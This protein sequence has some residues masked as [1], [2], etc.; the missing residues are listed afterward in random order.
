MKDLRLKEPVLPSVKQVIEANQR[1]ENNIYQ[2]R[3]CHMEQ[4]SLTAVISDCDHRAIGSAGGFGWTPLNDLRDISL[5]EAASL[6]C[7]TIE[8]FKQTNKQIISY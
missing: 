5:M 3:I 1:F 2:E 4:P 8:S 7:W 6:A